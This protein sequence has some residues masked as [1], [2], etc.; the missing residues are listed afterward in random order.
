[1]SS[2]ANVVAIA[3]SAFKAASTPQNGTNP[4]PNSVNVSNPIPSIA[5]L[6]VA[7]I[8]NI[9]TIDTTPEKQED[10]KQNTNIA[11]V[12]LSTLPGSKGEDPHTIPVNS[13]NDDLKKPPGNAAAALTLAISSV[14]QKEGLSTLE[15]PDLQAAK[16]SSQGSKVPSPKLNPHNREHVD[17]Q[18]RGLYDMIVTPTP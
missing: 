3:A 8:A 17:D 13:T 4:I 10:P 12:A 1:M 5:S 15:D 2:P 9:E 14:K 11:K 16:P 18:L 7:S 6:A